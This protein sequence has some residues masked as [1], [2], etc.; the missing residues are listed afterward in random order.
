MMTLL[1]GL[2]TF[3]ADNWLGVAIAAGLVGGWLWI[4]RELCGAAAPERDANEPISEAPRRQ[5][6]E[7]ERRP[8][9][10]L[11]SRRQTRRTHPQA[12]FRIRRS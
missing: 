2:Y 7:L 4:C 8:R 6:R 9:R 5:R 12:S 1:T 3:F 11:S 10:L